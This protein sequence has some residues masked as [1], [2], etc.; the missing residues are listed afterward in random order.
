LIEMPDI[1]SKIVYKTRSEL[2]KK[3][4]KVGISDF[5]A[6][7]LYE[8]PR[9]NFKERLHDGSNPSIIA[10]IKKASPSRGLIREDFNVQRIASQYREAGASALSILTEEFFFQGAL[11]NLKLARNEVDIPLLRKDFIIDPYQIEEARA[12]GADAVLLIVRITD[13]NQLQELHHAAE[14]A[15][16]QCLVECYD[17]ED[18]NRIDF[19]RVNIIGVNNR[20]L[21][22][23]N[24]HLHQ[25][26][27]LL[28]KAPDEIV[29]VSE[30]GLHNADDLQYLRD[31]GIH[32]ALIGE[33]FMKQDHP[34]EVLRN[35]LANLN[36]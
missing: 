4:K 30:S 28:N 8:R 13:G 6:F 34:G 17:Q 27:A 16:L 23:F 18:Y 22:T 5:Q 9:K 14:E 31:N 35:L 2:N 11:E 26:V 20:D 33:Y 12:Y 29:K 15:E 25:G 7:E 10:E 19:E 21:K 32:A 36:K 24:V 3:K 1:L